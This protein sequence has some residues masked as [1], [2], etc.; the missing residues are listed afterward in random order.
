MRVKINKIYHDIKQRK[1]ISQVDIVNFLK[2]FS[3]LISAGVPIIKTC[4]IL[5]KTQEKVAMR[6]LIY[7]I[8]RDILTGKNIYLSL[9]KHSQ[10]FDLFTCHL[11]QIGEHSGKLDLT[12]ARVTTHWEGKLKFQKHLKQV[13]FYPCLI[14]FAALLMTMTM[15][16]FVIP[17]FAELFH[18]HYDQL[19]AITI[20]IFSFSFFLKKTIWLILSSLFIGSYLFFMTNI[21]NQPFILLK[22]LFFHLPFIATYANKIRITQFIRNLSI[23]FTSGIPIVEALN[24]I[25]QTS[26]HTN[27]ITNI[28]KLRNL[29]NSGRELHQAMEAIPIFPILVIQ[30][31]KIGEESG[32]LD[33]ALCKIADFLE[34]EIEALINHL[35]Q[36]LEPLIMLVLGVLIGGLI[37]GMYLPVFKLG[38][39]L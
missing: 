32:T 34:A 20:F 28:I 8:K 22:N 17:R 23:T 13:L 24:L 36:L 5:E 2:H 10:Y 7:S 16:L 12:L 21:F 37:I 29:I 30:M 4:D 39:T 3:T 31:V 15:I 19:P 11:I 35:N 14:S 6:I 38:T 9:Q 25:A 1:R 27:M 26:H 33:N 18:D